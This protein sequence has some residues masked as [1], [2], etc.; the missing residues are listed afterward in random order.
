MPNHFLDNI[1]N[2]LMLKI[3][4]RNHLLLYLKRRLWNCICFKK[5]KVKQK[6][7]NTVVC[8]LH[9]R[10]DVKRNVKKKIG[11]SFL[12]LIC[13]IF[14][15]SLKNNTSLRL[16]VG[17]VCSLLFYLCLVRSSHW[18][19]PVKVFIVIKVAGCRPLPLLK[20]TLSHMF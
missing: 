14:Y 16:C 17:I 1:K 4:K 3:L 12:E 7:I 10:K 9:K 2:I 19:I 11:E 20:L 8:C 15:M 6:R 18:T 13:F 5:P